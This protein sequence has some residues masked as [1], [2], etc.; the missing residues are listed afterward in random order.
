MLRLCFVTGE[1]IAA[2]WSAITEAKVLYTDNVFEFSAARRLRLS[3]DLSQPTVVPLNR[4]MWCGV[5][6]LMCGGLRRRVPA[7]QKYQSKRTDS[8]L[9]TILFSIMVTTGFR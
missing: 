1:G 3:E 2:E 7:R 5:R 9:P 6:P 4:P 8:F